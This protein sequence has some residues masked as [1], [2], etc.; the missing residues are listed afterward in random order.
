MCCAPL[1]GLQL[2]SWSTSAKQLITTIQLKK[3]QLELV[4]EGSPDGISF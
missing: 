4:K 2:S 1:K 3:S